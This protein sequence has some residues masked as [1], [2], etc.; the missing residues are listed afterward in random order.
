MIAA[1]KSGAP[2]WE[3]HERAIA[4]EFAP[5][6]TLGLPLTLLNHVTLSALRR[7]WRAEGHE[8]VI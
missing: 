6:K 7:D 8:I 5:R 2:P 1:R 3:L 4:G